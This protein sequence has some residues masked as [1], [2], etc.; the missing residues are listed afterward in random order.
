MQ[1]ECSDENALKSIEFN[2]KQ[3]FLDGEKRFI[4]DGTFRCVQ[5]AKCSTDL[6]SQAISLAKACLKLVETSQTP[7]NSH[8]VKELSSRTENCSDKSSKLRIDYPFKGPNTLIR[9]DA[10]DRKKID[11]VVR[12]SIAHDVD[13]F[14]ALAISTIESPHIT[15]PARNGGYTSNYGRIPIDGL[16]IAEALG[17]VKKINKNITITETPNEI[18]A[19]YTE[20]RNA[21]EKIKKTMG[22]NKVEL[23]SQFQRNVREAAA[24]PYEEDQILRKLAT[25]TNKDCLKIDGIPKS[26]LKRFCQNKEIQETVR[27]YAELTEKDSAFS[28]FRYTLPQKYRTELEI[29]YE[30]DVGYLISPP[31]KMNTY[32]LPGD[33]NKNTLVCIPTGTLSHGQPSWLQVESDND[34][35]S[36]ESCCAKVKGGLASSTIPSQLLDLFSMNLIKKRVKSSSKIPYEEISTLIQ[37]YNGTGCMG[38][39]EKMDNSCLTGIHMGSRPVYGARASDLIVNSLMTNYNLLEMIS[40]AA[41][42]LNKKVN[43]IICQSLGKGVHSIDTQTFLNQQKLFLLDGDKLEGKVSNQTFS[44]RDKN[45]QLPKTTSEIDSFKQAESKRKLACDKFFN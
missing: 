35:N 42:D 21:R 13:P 14:L 45:G 38:C 33:A 31:K 3:V 27:F 8:T 19:K 9:S 30:P 37:N 40:Q 11:S 10:Y 34:Y 41:F 5:D 22:E 18:H 29:K 28:Q 32:N 16:P 24:S 1:I 20:L 15:N 17:C 26:L 39:T 43:S 6:G 23:L 7:E 44:F 25:N 2:G 4:G 12:S 36:S